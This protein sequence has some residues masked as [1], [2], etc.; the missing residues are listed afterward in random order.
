MLEQLMKQWCGMD[1]RSGP[2]PRYRTRCLRSGHTAG[3][4]C[5][6]WCDGVRDAI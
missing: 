5:V 1:R 3:Y 2:Q 4:Q 6:E